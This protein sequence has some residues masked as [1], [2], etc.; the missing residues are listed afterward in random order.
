MDCIVQK[1][2]SELKTNGQEQTFQHTPGALILI[3]K[4][5]LFMS[6]SLPV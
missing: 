3:F 2:Q 1:V 4:I 6:V 5:L